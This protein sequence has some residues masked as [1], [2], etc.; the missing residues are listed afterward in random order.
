MEKM[1]T[2]RD[3]EL[4]KKDAEIAS[5]K[6][7]LDWLKRQIFGKKSERH[8]LDPN[9]PELPLD[10]PISEV[11][12]EEETITTKRKKSRKGMPLKRFEVPDYLPR[13][14]IFLDIR[15]DEKFCP[16]TG[17]P[18][19]ILR[20][21]VSEKLAYKPGSY[22]VKRYIRP[23]Y[24]S[25]KQP[26]TGIVC[27][28][29]PEMPIEKARVDVS[30]LAH[31]LVQKFAD[32]LP[33]YRIEEILRRSDI[34]IQRQTIGDWVLKLGEVLEPL[35]DLMF[36]KILSAERLFTDATG[37]NYLV[38]GQGTKKGYMYVYCGG[39]GDP[40]DKYPPYLLYE[41]TEDGK[42]ENT[43]K[44]LRTFSGLLHSD[45]HGAY[46]KTSERDDIS[47][48][49]CLAHA[50]RKFENAKEAPKVLREKILDLFQKIFINER[51][52]WDM[53]MD[54]RREFRQDT[55]TEIMDELFSTAKKALYSG[56]FTPKMKIR[57]ALAY[58]ISREK[59]C[60][61]FLTEPMAIIDNNLSERTVKPLVIGRKNWLFLGSKDSGKSTAAILSLVQTCRHLKINPYDYL[62]DILPRVQAHQASKLS[63]LLPDQWALTQ[64][65]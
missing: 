25:A 60:R 18:L 13:E 15:E 35:Y 16:E 44:R 10:I 46:D 22:F 54:E 26:Q 36:K 6:E 34:N 9:Q 37:L 20:Q 62:C 32:H 29:L 40:E 5:L 4:A 48:Q 24:T 63:E 45:A 55:Q 8:I 38:K 19:K 12:P 31:I 64:K 3:A 39:R 56:T 17:E 21:E 52:A 50:R 65:Q 33:I 41:F 42:H 58:M 23:V 57:E 7:Q 2:G 59:H 1:T 27:A 49:L 14:D 47:W 43:L 51:T 30:L 61:T 53:T 11:E 28:S